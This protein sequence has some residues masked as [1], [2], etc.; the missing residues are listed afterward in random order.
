MQT[1]ELE[2]QVVPRMTVSDRGTKATLKCNERSAEAL[3]YGLL[4]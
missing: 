1:C 2:Y 4:A 3:I